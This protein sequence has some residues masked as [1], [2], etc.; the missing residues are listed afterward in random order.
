[1]ALD[2]IVAIVEGNGEVKAVPEL[3]RRLLDIRKRFDIEI[4][5]PPINAHGRGNIT[6][7]NGLENFL[8][9]AE[10]RPDC[11]AILVLMDAERDCAKDVAQ[12]LALRARNLIT[13]IAIAVVAPNHM[14][15]NWFLASL[16]TLAGK[17]G[18]EANLPTVN[19][20]ESIGNPK[21]WLTE[22]MGPGR[23]YKENLDQVAM[24]ALINTDFV[25]QRSRSFRRLEH[26]LDELLAIMANE[27]SPKV[28]PA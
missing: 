15:E 1:M 28:T 12:K 3:L 20:P 2:S 10:K 25:K 23:I 26:A 24:S 6:K 16:E 14:F 19:N 11:K 18:L 21:K 13:H 17:R 4:S 9:V 7:P 22:H 8:R 5:K 27:E